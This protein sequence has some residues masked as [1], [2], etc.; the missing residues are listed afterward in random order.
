MLRQAAEE[1]EAAIKMR[2]ALQAELAQKQPRSL[3]PPT[4]SAVTTSQ[5]LDHSRLHLESWAA[6]RS[7]DDV[8][9]R[10]LD[11]L[12]QYRPSAPAA[13]VLAP[14]LQPERVLLMC[15]SMAAASDLLLR[16]AAAAPAESSRRS[17]LEN[18]RSERALAQAQ[19]ARDAALKQNAL[20]QEVAAAA[21]CARP[22]P[23]SLENSCRF[24]TTW[25]LK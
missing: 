3:A 7:I 4:A 11:E 18:E 21:P 20:L 12:C 19:A 24:A 25:L 1:K 16:P 8:M 2:A 13:C 14:P 15:A 10:V 23:F 22:R 6:A 5:E 17:Q 9:Q